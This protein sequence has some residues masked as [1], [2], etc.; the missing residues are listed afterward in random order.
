MLHCTIWVKIYEYVCHISSQQVIAPKWRQTYLIELGKGEHIGS[1]H[2]EF[3]RN[4]VLTYGS[5]FAF[6]LHDTGSGC[7]LFRF[8]ET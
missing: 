8:M 2:T 5:L 4:F 7:F 6:H 1:Y 3:G